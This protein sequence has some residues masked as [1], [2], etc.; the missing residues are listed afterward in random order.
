MP[1]QRRDKLS[2]KLK[3]NNL[4]ITTKYL[5]NRVDRA[6]SF[7]CKLGAWSK[8]IKI[9]NGDIVIDD[10]VTFTSN[11]RDTI[12]VAMSLIIFLTRQLLQA[13]NHL[14]IR[15]SVLTVLLPSKIQQAMA[16]DSAKPICK[17]NGPMLSAIAPSI[18]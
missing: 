18:R 13:S 15:L 1:V 4:Q 8:H 17:A 5:S 16:W 9:C 10:T 11:E 12:S 7:V 2:P 14:K 6:L 3:N